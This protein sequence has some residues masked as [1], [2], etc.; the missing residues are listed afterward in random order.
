MAKAIV[1]LIFV[2]VV[3][4]GV[5]GFEPRRPE[6]VY[7]GGWELENFHICG[8]YEPLPVAVAPNGDVYVGDRVNG[9]VQ[10]YGATGSFL[11]AWGPPVFIHK[12]I[13]HP[14]FAAEGEVEDEREKNYIASTNDVAVAG[15]GTVYVA[16]FNRVARFTAT[17]YLLGVWGREGGASGEFDSPDGIAAGADRFVYV[18]DTGN[19]RVQYFSRQG[20]FLGTWGSEGIG[21]GQFGRPADVAVAP[22]GNVYV[23]DSERGSVQYFTSTGSFLGGW[24]LPRG[25]L[26]QNMD[27]IAVTLSP[28]A[29]T[30]TSSSQTP[31]NVTSKF[32]RPR[33]LL[34][35]N[36]GRRGRAA[37]ASR[38]PPASPSAPPVPFT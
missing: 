8:F 11:G 26:W 16:D 14:I 20:K 13:A 4:L 7:A 38:I 5:S 23:L 29:R 17:G 21:P 22:N 24:L 28:S 36:A 18:A 19:H 10:Y 6:Y 34:G 12:G 32:F 27:A 3:M 25:G 31:G 33:V 35:E 9:R 30:G 37:V 2:V 15:D 1:G